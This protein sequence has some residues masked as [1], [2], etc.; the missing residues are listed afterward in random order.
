MIYTVEKYAAIEE[1]K[2]NYIIDLGANICVHDTLR[3]KIKYRFFF[4]GKNRTPYI[5]VCS[6]TFFVGVYYLGKMGVDRRERL[7]KFSLCLSLY[8]LI[9]YNEQISF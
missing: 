4:N 7:L 6:N 1:Y 8:H 5:Y 9:C 3:G 2:L